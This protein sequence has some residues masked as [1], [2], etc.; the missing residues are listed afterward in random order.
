MA[1]CTLLANRFE[2]QGHGAIAV[3]SSVAGSRTPIELCVRFGQS[4]GQRLH[5]RHASSAARQ[6]RASPHHQ[7]GFVDTPLTTAFKKGALWA[8]PPAV[9]RSIARAI[10]GGGNVLYTPF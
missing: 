6:G 1:L 10:I 8:S 5:Q 2:A 3:I 7:P 9:A 4:R